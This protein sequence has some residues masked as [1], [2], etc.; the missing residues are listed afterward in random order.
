MQKMTSDKINKS[1]K[2]FVDIMEAMNEK[3]SSI[4]RVHSNKSK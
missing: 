1:M 3:K 2:F 4:I